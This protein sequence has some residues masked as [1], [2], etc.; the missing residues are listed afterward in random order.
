MHSLPKVVQ[1]TTCTFHS[2]YTWFF[3]EGPEG[4]WTAVQGGKE[5]SLGCLLTVPSYGLSPCWQPLL[6]VGSSF[7]LFPLSWN[8]PHCLPSERR[9]KQASVPSFKA[10]TLASQGPAVCSEVPPGR[11][12]PLLQGLRLSSL[13]SFPQVNLAWKSLPMFSFSIAFYSLFLQN[14]FT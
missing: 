8:Q 2:F 9:A 10:S 7:H 5:P 13:G 3:Q 12:Q 1:S 4:Q 14:L 6:P 11:Q